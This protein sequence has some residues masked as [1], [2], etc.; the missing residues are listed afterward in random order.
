MKEEMVKQADAEEAEKDKIKPT[1]MVK[2]DMEAFIY[3][4]EFNSDF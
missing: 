4:T 2:D 1:S 3:T